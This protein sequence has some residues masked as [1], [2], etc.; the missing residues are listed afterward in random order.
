M[1]ASIARD[2]P[3]PGGQR[4][5]RRFTGLRPVPLLLVTRRF[6]RRILA[7]P[8]GEHRRPGRYHAWVNRAIGGISTLIDRAIDWHRQGKP[9]HPDHMP[10]ARFALDGSTVAD[11]WPNF[12][13]DGYG[14]W[15]WALGQH[16]LSTG[17]DRVPELFRP[18][19]ERVGRYLDAFALRRVSTSGRRVG[20]RFIPPPWHA[21]T[22]AWQRRPVGRRGSS[23]AGGDLFSPHSR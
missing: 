14:T 21:F 22:A 7:R 1:A 9:L 11:D 23:R 2:P 12:Q 6:I 19:V 3:Q 13:I 20:Q 5:L 16:L 4:G 15:L 17:Q 8:G 18:S 10:P